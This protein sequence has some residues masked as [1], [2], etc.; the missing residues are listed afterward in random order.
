MT[1][2]PAA[3]GAATMRITRH[4]PT[5]VG[6][7]GP[8]F[9]ALV[10]GVNVGVVPRGRTISI[11]LKP[12]SHRVEIRTK[13][14]GSTSNSVEL[15]ATTGSSHSLACEWNDAAFP[16]FNRITVVPGVFKMARTLVQ[17]GGVSKGAI[18]LYETS[19]TNEADG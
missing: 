8:R 4:R 11:H 19:G 18:C 15:N 10:D 2:E 12:G 9:F 16:L 14:G 1:V 5:Y 17:D 7:L 6:F 3:E 13:H